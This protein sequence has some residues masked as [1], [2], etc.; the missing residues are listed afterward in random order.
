MMNKKFEEFVT[1]TAFSLHLSKRQVQ[2]IAL[3][4]RG[5]KDQLALYSGAVY[6]CQRMESKGLVKHIQ[7]EGYQLTE[8][9]ELVFQLIEKVGLVNWQRQVA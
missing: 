5:D 7:G 3:I 4:G 9:G 1:S 6:S 2:C 8:E